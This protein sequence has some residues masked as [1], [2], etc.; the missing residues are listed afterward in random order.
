MVNH[1]RF[2]GPPRIPNV[3]QVHLM[4]LELQTAYGGAGFDVKPGEIGEN[5][6]T[7]GLDLLSLPTGTVLRMGEAAI[8]LT[9][10]RTPCFKLDRWREGL[11]AACLDRGP[12]GESRKP[13]VMGVV[14]QGGLIR[15]GDPIRVELPPEP[16]NPLQ[17]V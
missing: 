9:G 10:F 12:N 17:A 5:I 14:R 4:S 2:R 8:E 3:R 6:T 7:E 13:G 1:N 11:K 15:P 16:H